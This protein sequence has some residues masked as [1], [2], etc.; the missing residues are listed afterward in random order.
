MRSD[1]QRAAAVRQRMA[2]RRRRQD[3]L[4]R[5]ILAGGSVAACLVLIVGLSVAMPG[6]AATVDA[7]GYAYSRLAG[8]MFSDGTSLGYVV[9]GLLAFVLGVAVTLLCQR[10]RTLNRMENREDRGRDD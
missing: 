8:S 7:S 10:V 5:R 6:L 1:E 3:A 4:R 9:I 2:R